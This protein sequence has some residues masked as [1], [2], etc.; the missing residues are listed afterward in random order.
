APEDV[1]KKTEGSKEGILRHML[2]N[3]DSS[4]VQA[5]VDAAVRQGA[6]IVDAKKAAVV[7]GVAGMAAAAA[8]KQEQDANV[9]HQEILDLQCK[10]WAAKHQRLTDM[11]EVLEAE[12]RSL[13]MER[14]DSYYKRCRYWLG[15]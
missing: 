7:G 2:D 1:A 8:R 3:L 5:A 15:D 10:K 6:D 14:R 4:V 11:E 12:R 9:L 13:L